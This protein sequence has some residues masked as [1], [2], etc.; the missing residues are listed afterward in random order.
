MADATE[1]CLSLTR[2][3]K[4]FKDKLCLET[5]FTKVALEH[6]AKQ[7]AIKL[8]LPKDRYLMLGGA[9][10]QKEIENAT[11]KARQK[12]RAWAGL[13][14]EVVQTEFPDF[15]LLAAFSVFWLDE[16]MAGTAK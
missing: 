7:K 12:L 10:A 16:S 6:L 8:S 2:V 14:H 11:T 5:G 9:G 13:V 4:L 1:E 3:D 15:E